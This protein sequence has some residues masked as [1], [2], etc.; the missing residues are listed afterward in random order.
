MEL[1]SD[2][3]RRMRAIGCNHMR[4]EAEKLDCVLLEGNLRTVVSD[5]YKLARR[6][7]E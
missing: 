3:V 6:L 2:C 1:R 7:G 4:N 5:C